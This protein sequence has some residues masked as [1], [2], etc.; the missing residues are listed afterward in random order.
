MRLLN[1][2]LAALVATVWVS[3]AATSLAVHFDGYVYTETA[4]QECQD[5]TAWAG[6]D[7]YWEPGTP[8]TNIWGSGFTLAPDFVSPF[9]TGLYAAQHYIAGS[10]IVTRI[11]DDIMIEIETTDGWVLGTTHVYA[12][13]TPP[14]TNRG[15]NL[16][17]GLF[18]QGDDFDCEDQ[19][20]E[21]DYLFEDAA[22]GDVIY[23]AVHAEVCRCEP[24]AD[25]Q[26]E[27]PL[28]G[29][30]VR[31]VSLHKDTAAVLVAEVTT[32]A[33][34]YYEY[35]SSD[36]T[37]AGYFADTIISLVSPPG[38]VTPDVSEVELDP[39]PEFNS[40]GGTL[41]E[42][43]ANFYPSVVGET[44]FSP[45]QGGGGIHGDA[46]GGFPKATKSVLGVDFVVTVP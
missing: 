33:N 10:V 9:E 23:I 12:G 24:V 31:F 44:V 14:P 21:A 45:N 18:P 11:G 15:G 1:K 16:V 3:I 8:K 2:P 20:T 34:G 19:V 7:N 22:A 17:P 27:Q 26:G 4:V 38:A 30:T 43:Y 29:V 39:H 46:A 36:F 13:Q 25:I 40:A 5:E 37:Q 6:E 32:D 41:A 35:E 42:L 28:E